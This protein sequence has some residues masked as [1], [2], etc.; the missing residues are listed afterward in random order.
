VRDVLASSSDPRK[1]Q[2]NTIRCSQRKGI[3]SRQE[4]HATPQVVQMSD[5]PSI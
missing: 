2:N 3:S 1:L 4:A 5:L